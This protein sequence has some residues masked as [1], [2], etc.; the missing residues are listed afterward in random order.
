[1]GE[2]GQPGGRAGDPHH[3][4]SGYRARIADL[5]GDGR[6]ELAAVFAGEPGSEALLFGKVKTRCPARGAV[7]VWKVVPQEPAAAA[8]DPSAAADSPV[9]RAQGCAR[10][11]SR[12]NSRL[13][14][15]KLEFQVFTGR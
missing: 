9:S 4:C 13:D 11:R 12:Y 10:R 3:H 14:S 1:V 8:A 7:R 15:L 2:G 6:A 5:D